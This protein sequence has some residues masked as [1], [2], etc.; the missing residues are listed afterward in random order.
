MTNTNS[1]ICLL[2]IALLIPSTASAQL[3]IQ[4][5]PINS[6]INSPNPVQARD[7]TY[8]DIEPNRQAFH[9]LL[10]GTEGKFPLVIYFHGGGFT[11]GS[12]DKLYEDEGLQASAKFFLEHGVA[13]VSAGYSLI[14]TNGPDDQGVIKCLSDAKRALQFIRHHAEDLQIDPT[15]IALMGGSA[16]AGTALWL[17]MRDDMA[18]PSS[19]DP[20]MRESTRVVAVSTSASQSTYDIP[21]WENEIYTDF[22]TT[23]Q[24]VA[25]ILSFDRLS[26]FYGGL[27]SINQVYHDPALIQYR[28]DVDILAHMTDDDPPIYIKNGSGA[29]LPEQDLFHH[30][31]HGLALQSTAKAANI[32]EVK[33]FI[34]FLDIDETDGESGDEFLLR[35]LRDGQEEQESV[36]LSTPDSNYAS[37]ISIYPNPT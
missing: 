8:D 25:D 18:D 6:G 3:D 17:A 7:V 19:S 14:E 30:H 22:G 27:D 12:R 11:G 20:V 16:G 13:F 24:D 4:F 34:N 28:A 5:E 1:L 37:R 26:N 15:N 21:R 32:S 33:T 2:L 9:I 31:G 29:P 35:Y 10:P 36:V 23:L